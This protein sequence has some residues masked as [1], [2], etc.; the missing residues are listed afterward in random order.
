M[1]HG[2]ETERAAGADADA[3]VGPEEN[4]H[5]ADADPH[6]DFPDDFDDDSAGRES[7]EALPEPGGSGRS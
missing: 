5:V 4:E 6:P 2:I 1:A 7:E 3:G